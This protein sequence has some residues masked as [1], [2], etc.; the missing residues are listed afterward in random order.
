MRAE[1]R[2]HEVSRYADAGGEGNAAAARDVVETV[3]AEGVPVLIVLRDLIAA[4]QTLIGI[5]WQTGE[6]SIQQEHAATATSA[7]I[8]RNL[9][10]TTTPRR[11]RGQLVLVA[12]GEGEWHSLGASLLQQSLR[13]DGWD[14]V[15]LPPG[16]RA[17]QLASAIHDHG[18]AAV[19]ISCALPALLPGAHRLVMASQD[20]GTPA[21]VGGR[22]FGSDATRARGLGADGWAR[23]TVSASAT[24]AAHAGFSRPSLRM[25]HPA[26]GEYT[27]LIRHLPA[28]TEAIDE[29][30]STETAV[31]A[32]LWLVRS[33]A[34]ALVC[35]DP[36]ILHEDVAWHRSRSRVGA[37]A[38]DPLL[39]VINAS[40]P[41]GSTI[42]SALLTSALESPPLPAD[43]DVQGAQ[44]PT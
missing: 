27:T 21:I 15:V 33:L 4:A 42:A 37:P 38:V 30:V 5:R 19:A 39:E 43:I 28:I 2:S 41:L 1:I 22:G 31:D 26:F 10:Q 20:A 8:V 40:L 7:S 23:D 32:A 13:M 17:G 24:V 18:P 29:A 3:L 9:E 12:V 35:D 36:A 44:S 34:S 25:T 16:T 6:W 11:S 14:V